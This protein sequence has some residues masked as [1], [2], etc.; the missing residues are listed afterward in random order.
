[1]IS[2]TGFWNIE[3]AQ[4]D[5]EHVY[6]VSLSNTLCSIAEVL[7]IDKAYD[8]GC[9]S[10][11]YVHALRQHGIHATGFDG[12]PVT[13]NIPHCVVQDLTSNFQYEPV[14]FMMCLEVGEHIPKEFE[15]TL[16]SQIDKHL[17]P[18]GTLV[19]SWA[20]EG[21]CGLGH[22]NCQNNEY[23][24][25]TIESMGYT[26]K[27]APSKLLRESSTLWWFKNTILVF[28]KNK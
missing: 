24:I 12:N 16:L 25:R 22:V 9:G 14:D 28:K 10:G 2:N 18:N 1:M 19:L 15:S 3:G 4:F 7:G 6:D 26:F 17:N 8:F 21:Q 23:I 11:K 27:D 20:I 5:C 13:A